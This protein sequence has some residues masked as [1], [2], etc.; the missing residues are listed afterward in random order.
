MKRYLTLVRF[1]EGLDCI[2]LF[3]NI[4]PFVGPNKKEQL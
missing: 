4:L 2:C 1:H 3:F